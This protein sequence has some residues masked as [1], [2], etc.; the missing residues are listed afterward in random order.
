M[1]VPTEWPKAAND[2]EKWIDI[3]IEN[4][5]LIA[6]QGKTLLYATLVSTG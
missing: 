2:G 6:P 3:S 1:L 4:Q 5:V